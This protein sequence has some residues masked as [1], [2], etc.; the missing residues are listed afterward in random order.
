MSKDGGCVL[1]QM[2]VSIM[3]V[4]VDPC[5][6]PWAEAALAVAPLRGYFFTIGECQSPDSWTIPLQCDGQIAL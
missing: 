2:L 1:E 3:S 4:F 6:M 5:K